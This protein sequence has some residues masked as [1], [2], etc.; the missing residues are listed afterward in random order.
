M[1]A[2]QEMG[3]PPELQQLEELRQPTTRQVAVEL[4]QFPTDFPVLTGDAALEP[5]WDSLEKPC[6]QLCQSRRLLI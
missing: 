5:L 6:L 3:F 2:A 4:L 1:S